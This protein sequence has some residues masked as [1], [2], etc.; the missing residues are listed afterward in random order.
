MKGDRLSDQPRVRRA[1]CTAGRRA[2]RV[3]LGWLLDDVIL[4]LRHLVRSTL[5][6]SP[7]MPRVGRFCLYRL[8]G[9]RTDTPNILAG[10]V[11]LGAGRHLR[12]GSGTFVSG[13]CV[14]DCEA[15]IT[16]G[17]SCLIGNEAMIITSDH[18]RIDGRVEP[19]PTGLPVVIGDRVWLGARA[20]VRPGVMIADDV[21]VAAGAT[22]T[23]D[24]QPHGVYA[25]VPARRIKELAPTP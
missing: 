4:A 10:V 19:E 12:I 24:C 13:G 16:I 21:I 18:R 23:R 17:S 6:G 2:A 25:G 5:A 1:V 7:F 8:A 9:V 3:L 15:T 11:I 20:L 14:F 22:V